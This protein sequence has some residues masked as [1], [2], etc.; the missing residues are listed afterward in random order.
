MTLFNIASILG[1][2]FVLVLKGPEFAASRG[3][4]NLRMVAKWMP[5]AGANLEAQKVGSFLLLW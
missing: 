1:P 5:V 4:T 2:P 3:L